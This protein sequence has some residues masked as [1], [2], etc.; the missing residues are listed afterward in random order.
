MWLTFLVWQK[1]FKHTRPAV[2][3]GKKSVPFYEKLSTNL[4]IFNTRTFRSCFW[5][6]WSQLGRLLNFWDFWKIAKF[7]VAETWWRINDVFPLPYFVIMQ[8]CGSQRKQFGYSIYPQSFTVP[9]MF[10]KLRR[11]YVLSGTRNSIKGRDQWGH[12]TTVVKFPTSGLNL[13]MCHPMADHFASKWYCF[14]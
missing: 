13:Q 8:F 5:L 9:L 2:F 7:E 11:E 6:F 4:S 10:L 3:H 14:Y 12:W 1:F